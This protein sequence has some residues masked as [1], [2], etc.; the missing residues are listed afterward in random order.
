MHLYRHTEVPIA[1]QDGSIAGMTL[2]QI[3]YP[4]IVLY[5]AAFERMWTETISV[6]FSYMLEDFTCTANT[7]VAD[8]L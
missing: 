8:I 7:F 3:P 1:E 2:L 4:V 5:V 6:Y